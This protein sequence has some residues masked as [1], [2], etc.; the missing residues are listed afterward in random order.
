MTR[1]AVDY[2]NAQA[3]I[4]ADKEI[5]NLERQLEERI[6]DKKLNLN[7]KE[8]EEAIRSNKRNEY[9]E[10]VKIEDKRAYEIANR[11][12]NLFNPVAGLFNDESYH[13]KLTMAYDQATNL[14]FTE[15]A[16]NPHNIIYAGY[17][18]PRINGV[19]PCIFTD[20]RKGTNSGIIVINYI[21]TIGTTDQKIESSELQN[22]VRLLWTP[23]RES[24][25][26]AVNNYDQSDLFQFTLA[27]SSV[28][29]ILR[30]LARPLNY[31]NAKRKPMNVFT[32]WDKHVLDAMTGGN[33]NYWINNKTEI[34]QG[35]NSLIRTYNAQ[36]LPIGFDLTKRRSVLNGNIFTHDGCRDEMYIFIPTTY[37]VYDEANSKLTAKS[38]NLT[39]MCSSIDNMKDVLSSM[40]SPLVNGTVT[41][42]MAGDMK[43][44]FPK[45]VSTIRELPYQFKGNVY[46]NDEHILEA[47]RNADVHNW[48]PTSGDML[49]IKQGV[50]VNLDTYIYQ[51]TLI[52][53]KAV[54]QAL[55]DTEDNFSYWYNLIGQ[56]KLSG[57]YKYQHI[58]DIK[59]DVPERYDIMAGT[60]FQTSATLGLRAAGG[61]DD[62]PYS[63]LYTITQWGSEIIREFK[64]LTFINE[65]DF[66]N[67]T[68]REIYMNTSS[69][70]MIVQEYACEDPYLL[71]DCYERFHYLP[72]FYNKVLVD[73]INDHYSQYPMHLAHSL[74]NY[75]SMTDKELGALH[76][77]S[78]G[79]LV[80]ITQSNHNELE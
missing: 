61:P 80:S 25:S 1:T 9:L 19:N 35:L 8:L 78:F 42:I 62:Q 7:L 11:I 44:A 28:F 77:A 21:P 49:D 6:A 64:V 4:Q 24:N 54:L 68:V 14:P 2:N 27:S 32:A 53:H 36:M 48:L 39:D 72:Q 52:D 73:Q 10:K 17:D 38:L 66:Y 65:E 16:G 37:Y 29:E 5:K 71:I 43:K 33:A 74:Y 47:L 76:T 20:M 41:S 58:L 22:N 59:K 12:A 55:D 56:D 46:S 30:L 15:K 70:E 63:E 26:G 13:N 34:I 40:L 51:G 75:R 3:K 45:Q 57:T 31:I 50:T 23:V 79:S 69:L 60:R 18:V 67:N